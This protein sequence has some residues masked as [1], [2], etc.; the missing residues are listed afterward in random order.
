AAHPTRRWSA[1]SRCRHDLNDTPRP[2][3]MSNLGFDITRRCTLW[4]GLAWAAEREEVDAFQNRGGRR[5]AVGGSAQ[6]GEASFELGI[7]D[8][9]E[10][11]EGAQLQALVVGAQADVDLLLERVERDQLEARGHERVAN[12]L[13]C[14]QPRL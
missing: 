1:R 12:T 13:H 8:Q 3:V 10:R 6:A 7:A 5:F 4:C 11:R 14:R 2:R 9:L